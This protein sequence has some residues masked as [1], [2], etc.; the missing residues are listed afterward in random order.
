MRTRNPLLRAAQLASGSG[1][2]SGLALELE[3]R[4]QP[5]LAC[6]PY[7]HAVVVARRVMDGYSR[8]PSRRSAR[9]RSGADRA[10]T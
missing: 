8:G 5:T 7:D 2:E 6:Q 9:A 4:Q 3:Q 1:R 10:Q